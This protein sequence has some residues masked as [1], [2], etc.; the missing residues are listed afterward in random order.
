MLPRDRPVAARSVGEVTPV[1]GGREVLRAGSRIRGLEG[2]SGGDETQE[3]NG[4]SA[5]GDPCRRERT[6]RG[7]K[8]SKRVKLARRTTFVRRPGQPGAG[9]QP[10]EREPIVAG[11][12]RQLRASAGVGETGGDKTAVIGVT[13]RRWMTA[14]EQVA[15]RGDHDLCEGKALKGEAQERSRHETRPWN[16]S[17]RK[18]LGGEKA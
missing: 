17:L 8:A 7:I 4:S 1:W 13:A 2:D 11:G 5:R 14:R 18:P 9:R 10:G 6:R 3:S 15:S 16:S 12:T